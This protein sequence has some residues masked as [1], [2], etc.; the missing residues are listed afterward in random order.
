M[1][2]VLTEWRR[3]KNWFLLLCGRQIL[4]NPQ[5]QNLFLAVNLKLTWDQKK[6]VDSKETQKPQLLSSQHT[7]TAAHVIYSTSHPVVSG[8]YT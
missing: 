2:C 4:I 5:L 3:Q 8:T 6:H 7:D 1:T